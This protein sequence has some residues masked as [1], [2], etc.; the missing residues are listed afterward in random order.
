MR[1]SI[2]EIK[3]SD[4]YCGPVAPKED[5]IKY[6]ENYTTIISSKTFR[7][8]AFKKPSG[9]KL[10]TSTTKQQTYRNVPVE[11]IKSDNLESHAV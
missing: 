4:W 1:L 6:F 5:I 8:K 11:E 2:S 7:K 10:P 3:D 9:A